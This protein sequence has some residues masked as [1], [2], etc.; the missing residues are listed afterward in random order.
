[1][2]VVQPLVFGAVLNIPAIVIVLGVIIGGQIAGPLGAIL[3]VPL[4]AMVRIAI[5]FL[6]VRLRAQPPAAPNWLNSD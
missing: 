3:A 1:G 6:R 5:D 4:A 2:R